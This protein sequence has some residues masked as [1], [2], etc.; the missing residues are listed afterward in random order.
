[1][2]GLVSWGR[3]RRTTNYSRK[4]LDLVTDADVDARAEGHGGCP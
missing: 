3:E 4:R 2:A 1:V